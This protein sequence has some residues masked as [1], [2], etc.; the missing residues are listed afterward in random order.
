MICVP[1]KFEVDPIT[2]ANVNSTFTKSKFAL[3]LL[4][5]LAMIVLVPISL[6]SSRPTEQWGQNGCLWPVHRISFSSSFLLQ[7]QQILFLGLSAQ[8]IGCQS[9]STCVV[10]HQDQKDTIR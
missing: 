9:V 7:G 2:T 10:P 4:F 8:Y 3:A 6:S 5:P 1:T